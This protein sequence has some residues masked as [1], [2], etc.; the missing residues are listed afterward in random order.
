MHTNDA[1][2]AI[3]RLRNLGIEQYMIAS[4]LKG[5]VAQRLVKATGKGEKG[6][7]LIAESFSMTPSLEEDISDCKSMAQIEANLRKKGMRFLKDDAM[8]KISKNLTTREEILK[9]ISL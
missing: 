4:V 2:G 3:S 9:E 8:D 7:I 5:A 6:R 1:L